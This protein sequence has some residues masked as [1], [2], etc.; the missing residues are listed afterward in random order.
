ME[1]H[2]N[3]FD[4]KDFRKLHVLVVGDLMLDR[5]WVGDADRVS[6]EAPVPI[7]TVSEQEY[8]PGGAA[9]VALN[10]VSLGANCTLVGFTGQDEAGEQ[11]RQSLS[12]AGVDCQFIELQEWQTPVKL[13]VLANSQ[14]MIRLDFEQKPPLVGE[15]ERLAL[16][17]NRVEKH[18]KE[19]R[20]LILE[21]YDK[22]VLQDPQAL[23]AAAKQNAVPVLVD[24]KAKP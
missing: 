16:L 21:D 24:P 10:V 1:D 7:V 3:S 6:P 5:Y 17:L 8:R 2:T 13:R 12:A 4:V 11:L 20:V 22:G 9:N 15:S 23:I 18:L 14:Q 19:A